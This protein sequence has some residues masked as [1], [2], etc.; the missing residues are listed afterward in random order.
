MNTEE[1]KQKILK[2]SVADRV[3]AMGYIH[4]L[5]CTWKLRVEYEKVQRI[6]PPSQ[7]DRIKAGLSMDK[8]GQ[9]VAE[10]DFITDVDV[11]EFPAGIADSIRRQ[12]DYL[13]EARLS[14]HG[15]IL[16]KMYHSWC[17]V[18]GPLV[19]YVEVEDP[20]RTDIVY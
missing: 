10:N 18:L 13:Q 17:R 16:H 11:T 19:G 7:E 4:T 15:D 9:P 12:L 8:N 14:E 6:L 20:K 5:Q 1:P 3:L 2:M